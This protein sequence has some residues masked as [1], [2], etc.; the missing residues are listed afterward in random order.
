MAAAPEPEEALSTRVDA[1]TAGGWTDQFRAER[2]G[3][4]SLASHRIHAFEFLVVDAFYRFEGSSDPDDEAILFAL[5]SQADG[6][7]GT[8]VIPFGPNA[9]ALEAEAGR[10]LLGEAAARRGGRTH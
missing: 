4:R 6:T 7:R 3:L 1:L 8:W 10:R 9:S 5:T 2:S